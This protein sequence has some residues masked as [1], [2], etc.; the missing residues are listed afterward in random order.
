MKM[1]EATYSVNLN[2]VSLVLSLDGTKQALEPLE[3]AE[4]STNPEEV[5]LPEA[6]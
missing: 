2:G 3:G 5:D 6:G 1:E 4:V